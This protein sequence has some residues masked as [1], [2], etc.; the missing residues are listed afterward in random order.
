MSAETE[1]TY[2][3]PAVK[4]LG[5]V[6]HEHQFD[7]FVR[8][9]LVRCG[10]GDRVDRDRY[11]DVGLLRHHGLEVGD[12]LLGLETGVGDRDDVD[13]FGL[14]L[15][16]QRVRLSLRPVVAGVVEHQRRGGVLRL[17]FGE[18]V[19]GQDDGGGGRGLLAVRSLA[20]DR[21]LQRGHCCV[22]IGR[23]RRTRRERGA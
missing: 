22:G 20:H 10:R 7:A 12:L 16:L 8:G 4:P 9:G 6:V 19:V 14:E 1:L 3:L 18:F 2:S 15:R 11:D 17:D 21:R 23:P 13:P 5:H